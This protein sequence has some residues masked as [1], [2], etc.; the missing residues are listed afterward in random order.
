MRDRILDVLNEYV[1]KYGEELN[2]VSFP[3]GF[4]VLTPNGKDRLDGD[5]LMGHIRIKELEEEIER[6]RDA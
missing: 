1:E 4:N 2:Y 5:S 3:E 6:L